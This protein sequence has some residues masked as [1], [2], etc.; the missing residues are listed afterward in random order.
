MAYCCT[1]G[2]MQLYKI[3]ALTWRRRAIN[4]SNVFIYGL[5]SF[6]WYLNSMLWD[7]ATERRRSPK[8]NLQDY[9]I[10]RNIEKRRKDNIKK[11]PGAFGSTLVEESETVTGRDLGCSQR[12]FCLRI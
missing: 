3:T 1:E 7:L 5:T 8:Q 11:D 6:K 2:H 10:R 12:P 9:D 4:K